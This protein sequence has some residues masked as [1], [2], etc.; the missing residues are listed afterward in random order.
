MMEI[1]NFLIRQKNLRS[2]LP[3]FVTNYLMA[4]PRICGIIGRKGEYKL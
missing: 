1:Y 4:R 2:I 3:A